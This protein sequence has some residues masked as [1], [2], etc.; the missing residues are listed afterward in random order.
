M[1]IAIYREATSKNKSTKTH[2]LIRQD[3]SN[4]ATQ[5]ENFAKDNILLTFNQGNIQQKILFNRT[6]TATGEHTKAIKDLNFKGF[7]RINNDT[8]LNL[9]NNL[10]DTHYKH[11]KNYYENTKTQQKLLAYKQW[12]E[13][14]K[15]KDQKPPKMQT[16]YKGKPDTLHKEFLIAFG[17]LKHTKKEDLDNTQFYRKCVA[18]AKK[19]LEAMG[20][21]AQNL[22]AITFHRDELTTH[23]HVRYTNFDFKHCQSL[24]T[25]IETQ[26][27]KDPRKVIKFR[28]DL[29]SNLQK[30]LNANF[31][32]KFEPQP[33]DKT[34]KHKTK[35]EWLAQQ[36]EALDT[37]LNTKKETLETNYVGLNFEAIA[38]KYTYQEA[39]EKLQELEA[40]SIK[41]AQWPGQDKQDK[42]MWDLFVKF[43]KLNLGMKFKEYEEAKSTYTAIKNNS[44]NFKQPN[45]IKN[46]TKQIT[47]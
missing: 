19:Q 47:I 3:Y 29:L 39:K 37:L 34:R 33:Q 20:L 28:Q 42:T 11:I 36:N 38:T 31:G 10:E 43:L 21:S 46:K 26:C 23:L 25:T 9:Y 12:E 44:K 22:V 15:P 41:P 4:R 7:E 1:T 30:E 32:F 5:G 27:K 8:L 13:K 17:D 24:N 18:V 2:L 40:I 35:R 14:G 6:E 45:L 16:I